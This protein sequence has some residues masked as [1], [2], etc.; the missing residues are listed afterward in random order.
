MSRVGAPADFG[1]VREAFLDLI[2]LDPAERARRLASIEDAG[3][4]DEVSALLDAQVADDAGSAW[5]AGEGVVA[6]RETVERLLVDGTSGDDLGIAAVG[7][8][9]PAAPLPPDPPGYQLR[10]LL[11][12][13]GMGRVYEAWQPDPG[14]A[15]A[16]KTVR[17]MGSGD[18]LRR[19]AR[20]GRILA[21]LTH[22]GIAQIY[23]TGFAEVGGG[24]RWPYIAM[25]LVDGLSVTDAMEAWPLEQKLARFADLCDAVDH[26]HRRGVVH[27]D[28]KPAN[29]L[30]D[31]EGR[32]KVLD[33]GVAALLD[34]DDAANATTLAPLSGGLAGTLSY[35]SPEQ[36]NVSLGDAADPR[37]DVFALGV[38]LYEL[39]AGKLPLD[40]SRC[41]LADA[42]RRIEEE[43]P[44]RLTRVG[45]DIDVDLQT[46]VQTAM[47]K[48]QASRYAS[49]AALAGDLRRYLNNEPILARAPTTLYLVRKFARRHRAL[50][51]ACLAAT[52]SLVAGAVVSIGFAIAAEHSR[53]QAVEAARVAD[54]AARA[55]ETSARKADRE[56]YVS[57]LLGVQNAF[58][59]NDPLTARSLL[60]QTD[61]SL[62]GWEW[63]NLA[64]E[65]TRAEAGIGPIEDTE[66]VL[67]DPELG[68]ED[69]PAITRWEPVPGIT[70]S[71][72]RNEPGLA[73]EKMKR[74]WES[75]G[76]PPMVESLQTGQL[77]LMRALEDGTELAT[78]SEG[79]TQEVWISHAGSDEPP[80]LRATLGP[81]WRALSPFWMESTGPDP[82]LLQ[83]GPEMRRYPRPEGAGRFRAV[84]GSH[85]APIL[86]AADKAGGGL[87]AWLL[88]SGQQL[89]LPSDGEGD[90]RF[91]AVDD[92]VRHV[93][94]ARRSGTDVIVAELDSDEPPV[95][96]RGHN[97]RA[98]AG[99]F[100]ADGNLFA[101][102][103]VDGTVIVWDW[104]RGAALKVFFGCVGKVRQLRFVDAADGGRYAAAATSAG[105]VRLW[106][107]SGGTSVEAIVH[108]G[109][110]TCVAVSPDGQLLVSGGGDGD[111]VLRDLASGREIW[112]RSGAKAI[113]EVAFS[114][115]GQTLLVMPL[116]RPVR[117]PVN[118]AAFD[119]ATGEPRAMPDADAVREVAMA[120]ALRDGGQLGEALPLL[121]YI[122]P[123]DSGL[124]F[125]VK[126]RAVTGSALLVSRPGEPW[127]MLPPDP[128]GVQAWITRMELS[129]DGTRIGT[130]ASDGR[131]RMRDAKTGELLWMTEGHS[132]FAGGVAFTP[133]GTRLATVGRDRAIRIWDVSDGKQ[134]AILRVDE[135]ANDLAFALDGTRLITA[136]QDGSTRLW[137]APKSISLPTPPAPWRPPE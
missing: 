86:V 131:V 61:P 121:P 10:R 41:G 45:R 26:A 47:A 93:A 130:V 42:A 106:R 32:V 71:L 34:P 68:D 11:G 13:G 16:I 52:A 112:R 78:I 46:I 5:S 65:L 21:R 80:Q 63:R 79:E 107:L 129:P 84:A 28:L 59:A 53:A 90:V 117:W 100:S 37:V 88:N 134:M 105:E 108:N 40:V 114:P 35:M 75:I 9:R 95:T 135:S 43:E 127:S 23:Q 39:L 29:V 50:V 136:H 132:A 44:P 18:S 69:N 116:G 123:P 62:R 115:D 14:R 31:A 20:E 72:L 89:P 104:R 27:R 56:N 22:P 103:G 48:S 119:V 94:S 49:A 137:L 111:V 12:A 25:E 113:G 3:L 57:S 125:L 4:R 8:D 30:I 128:L 60:L 87:S 36:L 91:L 74:Y 97:L 38:M 98:I 109:P 17:P 73:R 64:H 24:E 126:R 92:S 33:F 102:G 54:D 124:R 70:L 67:R 122:E 99:A 7:A 118:L 133:D 15:V 55:A 82:T 19:F 51:A 6:V 77:P 110:A 76:R 85:D 66:F 1:A 58:A 2:D 83:L 81:E 120:D 101:T 96:L